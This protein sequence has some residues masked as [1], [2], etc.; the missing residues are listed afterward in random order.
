MCIGCI[1]AEMDGPKIKIVR[2]CPIMPP[3]FD[4]NSLGFMKTK[5]KLPTPSGNKL[6]STWYQNGEHTVSEKEKKRRDVLVRERDNLFKLTNMSATMGNIIK[7]IGPDV[8][9]V[10]QNAMFNGVDR[11]SVV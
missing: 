5:K 8:M 6:L 11:K 3:R 7:I 9:S 1:A 2:S 4:I 10:E